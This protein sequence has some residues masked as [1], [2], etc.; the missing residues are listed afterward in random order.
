MLQ[1]ARLLDGGASAA[2]APRDAVVAPPAP[3]VTPLAAPAPA[4]AV[5]A[6]LGQDLGAQV[7]RGPPPAAVAVP[8]RPRHFPPRREAAALPA[9]APAPRE[10]AREDAA[11]LP[12][13][14]PSAAAEGEAAALGLG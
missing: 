1:L 3:V 2:P 5:V 9:A 11:P 6:S 10:A 13:K 8:S 4:A 12:K 7:A 14:L